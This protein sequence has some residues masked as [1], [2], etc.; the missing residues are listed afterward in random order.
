MEKASRFI[1]ISNDETLEEQLRSWLQ[2]VGA[3]LCA[4]FTSLQALLSRWYSTEMASPDL[5]LIDLDLPDCQ[6]LDAFA[7]VKVRALNTPVVALIDRSEAVLGLHLLRMGASDYLFRDALNAQ[8]LEH[9]L[10]RA[11]ERQ[12][13]Q[14]NL[15]AYL[16]ELY[17]SEAR[18]RAILKHY[19]DGLLILDGAG[20]ILMANNEAQRLLGHS[21]MH[22]VGQPLEA[23]VQEETPN[24]ARLVGATAAIRLRM[25]VIPYEEDDSGRLVLLRPLTEAERQGLPTAEANE[26]LLEAIL[27]AFDAAVLIVDE[28]GCV[29]YANQAALALLSAHRLVPGHPLNGVLTAFIPNECTGPLVPW[30]ERQG[31]IWNSL[32]QLQNEQARAQTYQVQ[33]KL[34]PAPNASFVVIMLRPVAEAMAVYGGGVFS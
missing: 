23:F 26:T 9:V 5:I 1:L 24:F 2:P 7:E 6:G 33:L 28:T 8:L 20:R 27:E 34:L 14:N 3:Q 32:W 18:L 29:A 15:S 16:Q 30:L 4:R 19:P 21:E 25:Q 31:G 10:H 12:H 22:L 11:W 17:T 13:V